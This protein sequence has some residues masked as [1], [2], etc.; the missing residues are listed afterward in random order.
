MFGLSSGNWFLWEWA[1][2][3]SLEAQRPKQKLEKPIA[4]IRPLSGGIAMRT[5]ART[6]TVLGLVCLAQAPSLFAQSTGF[7][8]FAWY[9]GAQGGM[10]L[11]E[12]QT[13]TLGAFPAAG[14]HTLITAKRTGLLISLD[15]VIA[16]DETSSYSDPAV[17]GGRRTVVFNDVR[18][19]SFTL[20]AFPFNGSIQPYFGVGFGILQTVNEY[21]NGPFNSPAEADQA[22]ETANDL[23]THTFPNLTAGAQFRLGKVILF[24]QYEIAGAPQS[25]HL[26]V[27]ATHTFNAGLRIRI[28]GSRDTGTGRE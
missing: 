2:S 10:T 16:T 23:G 28:G 13:Q 21:P 18:K 15:E 19:L 7:D 3:S 20:L 1:T 8:K 22:K 9:L 17:V 24:G 14:A 25:D 6:A 27:G 12:T 4:A 11:L 26:L 5:I